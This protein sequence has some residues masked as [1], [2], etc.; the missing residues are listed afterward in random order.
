ME[1]TKLNLTNS[2]KK[3]FLGIG[4][5]ILFLIC[6]VQA[7]A[8]AGFS[9]GP[10]A[11]LSVNDF[12][13][14]DGNYSARVAWAA[15]LF[16]NIQLGE[17]FSVQPEFLIHQKGATQNVNGQ[18][19]EVRLNYFSVPLLGKIMIPINGMFYPH[20][21]A[22]PVYNYRLN[23]KYTASDNGTVS[24]NDGDLKRTEIAGALGAGLDIISN[25]VY[26]NLDARY[27]LGFS[28]LG[29]ND[30]NVNI[31]NRNWTVMAGI[32]LRFGSPK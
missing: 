16:A 30:N 17:M 11:G 31:Q 13:S 21:L 25:N 29:D 5:I 9:I 2:L 20:I 19:N 3:V 15:G 14:D 27:N 22:G 26:F 10:K 12:S 23:A 32:G 18:K 1:A 6:T 28:D 24:F 8:Q 7:N 4:V